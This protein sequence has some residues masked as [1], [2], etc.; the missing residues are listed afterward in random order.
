M[1]VIHWITPRARPPSKKN[2]KHKFVVSGLKGDSFFSVSVLTVLCGLNLDLDSN[3]FG[4]VLDLDLNLFGLGLG[5]ISTS[6]GLGLDKGG[7]DYSPG[8]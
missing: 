3:F 4:L 8:S 5:S 6:P 1:A 2:T 7:L